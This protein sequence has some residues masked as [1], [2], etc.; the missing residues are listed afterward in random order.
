[1]DR[2][3]SSGGGGWGR[4]GQGYSPWCCRVR[5]DLAT[6]QH[7]PNATCQL[8]SHLFQS[9]GFSSSE[10]GVKE[11]RIPGRRELSSS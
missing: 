11:T 1:M 3:A 10:T 5:H 9:S 4:V 2:G 7:H 6:E 8:S